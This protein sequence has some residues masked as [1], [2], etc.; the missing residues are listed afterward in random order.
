MQGRTDQVAVSQPPAQP[1][2]RA[3][4]QPTASRAPAVLLERSLPWTESRAARLEAVSSSSMKSA[5]P[6]AG[7][8]ATP[9]V[10]VPCAPTC[11][12]K[13]LRTADGAGRGVS[14]LSGGDETL[15]DTGTATGGEAGVAIPVVLVVSGSIAS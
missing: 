9:L 11:S 12:P 2:S 4:S 14:K 6:G 15:V 10:T 13:P 3:A 1:S 7:T 5:P 8:G